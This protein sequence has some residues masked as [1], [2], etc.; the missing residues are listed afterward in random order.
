MVRLIAVVT[1]IVQGRD[2]PNPMQCSLSKYVLATNDVNI[3]VSTSVH[4]YT[5]IITALVMRMI[6]RW[7]LY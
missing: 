4:S 7:L 6:W 5:V 3:S 2:R 1:L